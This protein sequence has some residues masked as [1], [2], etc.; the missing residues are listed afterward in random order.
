MY[1]CEY[2][3]ALLQNRSKLLYPSPDYELLSRF[4]FDLVKQKV[5]FD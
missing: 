1:L 4:L 5:W 3:H 2:L